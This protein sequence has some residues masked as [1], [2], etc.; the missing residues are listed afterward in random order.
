MP[1]SPSFIPSEILTNVFDGLKFLLDVI[2]IGGRVMYILVLDFFTA[3]IH[4]QTGTQQARDDLRA[5]TTGRP[6]TEE[7]VSL[8]FFLT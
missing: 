8:W 1:I 2:L 6:S 4:T 3:P 7:T 5:T